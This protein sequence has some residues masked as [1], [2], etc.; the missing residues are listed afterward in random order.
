MPFLTSYLLLLAPNCELVPALEPEFTCPA[1]EEHATF[2]EAMHSLE[3]YLEDVC[4]FGKNA[5]GHV[6]VAQGKQKVAFDAAKIKH[7]IEELCGPMFIHVS[8][9]TNSVPPHI[10]RPGN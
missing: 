9:R 4:G 7:L 2:A 8:A 1:V 3:T 10:L 5:K 6:V